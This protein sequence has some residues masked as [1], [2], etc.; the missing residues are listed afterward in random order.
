MTRVLQKTGQ[1][2]GNFSNWLVRV[3]D[4]DTVYADN[5][6]TS[7]TVRLVK[8]KKRTVSVLDTPLDVRA[9]STMMW[10]EL[11]PP[12]KEPLAGWQPWPKSLVTVKLH[13]I[14]TVWNAFG[15]LSWCARRHH[16][17]GFERLTRLWFSQGKQ[18]HYHLIRRSLW[19]LQAQLSPNRPVTNTSALEDI[20]CCLNL[21]LRLHPWSP[22]WFPGRRAFAAICGWGPCVFDSGCVQCTYLLVHAAVWNWQSRAGGQQGLSTRMRYKS[23][24][25]CLPCAPC[26]VPP[27]HEVGADWLDPRKDER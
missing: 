20:F 27:Q 21:G 8:K 7:L 3:T 15:A 6:P 26:S 24:V 1:K 18:T 13:Y 2:L 10:V 5:S 12:V 4:L 23:H 9:N 11:L 19:S 14:F 22:C 25:R 16:Q 17:F